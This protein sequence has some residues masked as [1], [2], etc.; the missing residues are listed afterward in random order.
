VV[1][2]Q[3]AE[4]DHLLDL[5]HGADQSQLADTDLMEAAYRL[6]NRVDAFVAKVSSVYADSGEWHRTGAK[7]AAAAVATHTN[8][9]LGLARAM[10]RYGKKL[11]SMGY[12]AEAYANGEIGTDH[13]NLFARIHNRATQEAFGLDE[14]ALVE[15]ARL[16]R[17]SRFKRELGY[18]YARTDPQ[19]EERDF[20]AETD[21]RSF[22]YSRVLDMFYGDLKLDPLGGEVVWNALRNIEQELFEAD[23]AEARERV[24]DNAC[25]N[26]LRR[27][28]SQRLA[29]ALVELATRAMSVPA[30]ARRPEPLLCILVGFE[31][32]G[33]TIC[34]T[35]GGAKLPPSVLAD[36]IDEA[37]IERIVFDAPSRVIDVGERRRLFTGATRRAVEIRDRECF[38][39]TCEE[40][41]DRCQVDHVIPYAAGGP[42]II[43][44]GRLAC[45]FH[46]R[47]RN[48]RDG[49]DP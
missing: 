28:A 11:K 27:S 19:R 43:D 17:F 22:H 42:T 10:V 39:P 33:G 25:A 24:G 41:I 4:V 49:P 47:Q 8:Q 29:D 46:N 3:L 26:D 21:R 9:P 1:V 14:K 38:H 48:S 6:K 40:P 20:K 12:V 45:G 2:D 15:G 44:N 31:T 7:S 5:L 37:W 34:E 30:D 23:W 35:L 32:F 13:V 18:W 16:E 36:F